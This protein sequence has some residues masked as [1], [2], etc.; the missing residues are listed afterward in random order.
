MTV[1]YCLR[2]ARGFYGENIAIEHE[3][4]RL[5][6]REL[7]ALVECS[8]RKL[9]AL[10][11]SKGDRVAVLMLNSPEYLELYFSTAMAGALIVPLNTRWH[12]NE[13]VY[14][15]SDSGSKILFVDDKFAGLVPEIRA[16]LPSIERF[17]YAGSGECPEGLLDWRSVSPANQ[18]ES[19]PEPDENDV[20]GLFYTSGTT[21]GPKGAMLTHR[22]LYSNAIH[23]LLPP[24]SVFVEGKWLHAAPMFH[25]ADV[26]AIFALTLRG[27]THCFLASFD[28]L[29]VMQAIERH[30]ITTL[31][32]VPT[33]INMV[34]NH[35]EFS[36]YDLSSLRRVVYGASP[37]PLPLLQQAM[38]QLRCEF[39][40]G[41]G[42]TEVSPLLTRLSAEDHRFDNADQQ[43]A[44]VKSAGKAI[45][46]VEV[47]VVD[48]NDRDVPPGQPGEIIARGPNVMK[49]YWNRPEISAEVLRGGWM[50]TGDLG[51]FD[52]EGF[53]YIL[54]RK[55]DMIKPGGENV[56]SPEVESLL[57][58]HPA[59]LEAAVIGVPHET[60][61]ETIR[62]VVVLRPG[63][64]LSEEELIAW[65]R[66]RLTH[67]KCPTSVVF[68]DALPKGGTGKIQKSVLRERFGAAG[69]ATAP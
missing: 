47:R 63:A 65:S 41:Y 21:G 29:G 35:P 10:G 4:R 20:A 46:G 48:H 26:G 11:V 44:P 16:A 64:S 34:V 18:P 24:S 50:H 19:F 27:V 23:S 14:T 33:M 32:L 57:C 13:I 7:Y 38:Q 54:D 8:A 15:L 36:R 39:V 2:R 6:Y 3:G 5:T 53:L 30:R 40:Q 42:M 37:M 49:G 9:V 56:Y 25:L 17:V 12:L 1:N 67:F 45:M 58:A 60:W 28:P 66:E 52:E 68:T 22:N 31:V 51:V 61:G 43:F 62:A 69:G 55:K 59:V